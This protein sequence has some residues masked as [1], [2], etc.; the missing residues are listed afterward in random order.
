MIKDKTKFVVVG[1]GT[2]GAIFATYTKKK[3]GDAA[4]VVLLYDHSKPGIGVGE[5]LTLSFPDYLNF[6]G[7]SAKD[8][9]KEV[10]ATVKYAMKFKNWTGDG[11]EF[12]HPFNNLYASNM[13]PNLLNNAFTIMDEC[14]GTSHAKKSFTQVVDN[15]SLKPDAYHSYHIDA[16]RLNK[17][18]EKR[19]GDTLTI[20]DG[21][22]VDVIKNVENI[23]HLV[24]SDGQKVDGDIFVDATGFQSTLY[25]H[26]NTEW[27][28]MTSWLPLDSFIP[29]PIFGELEKIPAHTTSEATEHGWFLQVP[30]QN[31]WGTGLLYCSKFTTDEEAIEHLNEWSIKNHGKKLENKKIMR[32][33]SGYWKDQWV[34]NCICTGLS[35]GFVEP[36]EA[37]NIHHTIIQAQVFNDLFCPGNKVYKKDVYDYN[38]YMANFYRNVYNYIRYCYTGCKIKSKFW[39]YMNEN[40]PEEVK[41]TSEKIENDPL[42]WLD[43]SSSIMFMMNNYFAIANGLGRANKKN[44][45]GNIRK[46]IGDFYYDKFKNQLTT[47]ETKIYELIDH[48]TYLEKI[49]ND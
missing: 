8:L 43:G 9:F 37:T 44:V 16:T 5:S 6:M 12:F 20:I 19:F 14:L 1:G 10:N 23:D 25:K 29:N 47:Q 35:S 46:R 26:M 24:L 32:F 30:L 17:Y 45:L 4:E 48:K 27:I 34:G 39:T 42:S 40:I 7:I 21:V 18:L 2:A 28:D 3:W 31:R 38:R 22:V 33:K 49:K 11:S 41:Q 36:L 13:P 15:F